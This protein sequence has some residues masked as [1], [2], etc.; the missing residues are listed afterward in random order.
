[1]F[2]NGKTTFQVRAHSASPSTS[3]YEVTTEPEY[4]WAVYLTSLPSSLCQTSSNLKKNLH[5]FISVSFN[6]FPFDDCNPAD[7]CCI[8]HHTAFPDLQP[9]KLVMVMRD[10]SSRRL[11]RT[12]LHPQTNIL[13]Q[14]ARFSVL[15]C[16]NPIQPS[17]LVDESPYN[18][19]Q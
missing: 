5:S 9:L 11:T 8:S 2:W 6:H 3:Q 12:L 17:F 16:Q 13:S 14:R 10:A 19:L 1:M 4:R 7:S 18:L 15:I